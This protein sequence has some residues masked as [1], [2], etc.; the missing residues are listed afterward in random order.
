M[1]IAP[2][3]LRLFADRELVTLA[4]LVAA[5]AFQP[6]AEMGTGAVFGYESLLR[7]HDR[8]GCASPLAFLDHAERHGQLFEVE[9]LLAGRALAKFASLPTYRDATLFLNLDVR[10]IPRGVAFA[11]MLRAEMDSLGIP[12]SSVCFELSERFDN[13]GVPEFATLVS[14]VRQAGFKLA[15]DDYGAGHGEMNLLCDYQVDYIKIDRHMVAGIDLNPRKRHL[16]KNTVNMAHA[17]GIRVIAEGVE[18]EGELVTTRDLGADLVQGWHISRPE[19][20]VGRLKTSFPRLARPRSGARGASSDTVL[21][22][23]QMERLPSIRED[24]GIDRVFALFRNNPAQTFFP[25]LNANGEPRGIIRERTLKAYIYQPFGRDLLTNPHYRRSISQFV[26]SAPVIGLDA[27]ADQLASIFTNMEG[28]DCI[29]LTENM[30]YAGVVSPAAMV[31]LFNDKQL[32]SAREQNP[33]TGLPGNIAIHDQL[34]ARSRDTGRLRYFCYGDFDHFKPF[35][36]VYGFARGDKAITLFAAQMRRAF[37]E[38]EVFLGHIGGDDFFIGTVDMPRD[39]VERALTRLAAEFAAD[40]RTL[41]SPEDLAR[42]GIEAED[43]TGSQRFF[44][45]LRCS[46]AVL[47]VPEGQVLSDLGQVSRRIAELKRLAKR[48]DTGLV[49]GRLDTPDTALPPVELLA[50]G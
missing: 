6:I 12:A 44:P 31:R 15:I 10:L 42:G 49:L 45:L 48:S 28:N 17:L 16:F 32:K 38:G 21:I 1:S 35:N 7:G 4:K 11:D 5:S 14:H 39:K 50:A 41:Y 36:D 25:V 26:E 22:R 46:F 2:E 27:D 20:E 23:R 30:R 37:L 47:E 24:E 3:L 8:L 19:T 34:F 33:L 43:R 29:I 9:G 40:A 18:T 13:A